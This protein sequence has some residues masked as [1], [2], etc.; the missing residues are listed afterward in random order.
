MAGPMGGATDGHGP[1]DLSRRRLLHGGLAAGTAL[2]AARMGLWS[3]P[4]VTHAQPAPQPA[5]A[6]LPISGSSAPEL[7]AFDRVMT[8]QMAR[9]GLTG[10]ALALA[11]DGRLVFSH[12]Y[13][14]A[15]AETGQ[16]WQPTSL[17]RIAS[18]SKPF[19]AVAI[20]RLVDAG[21]LRLEDKAFPI[22][23]DLPPPANAPRDP[24]LDEITIQQLLQHTGGWD[25]AKSFDPQY[26]P[27]STWAAATLGVAVPPTAE[28]IVRFMLSWP[29]DFD[30]GT[31]YA[32]SNFGYNV[33]GRVIEHVTGLPY[34]DF[35]QQQVLA[36]AGIGDMRLGRTRPEERFPGEVRY[37]NLPDQALVPSVFPGVGYVPNGYGGYYMEA[38]DAH[39]GWIATAEDQLRFATAVDGQRGQ[40]L[41]RPETVAAMLHT[42]LPQQTAASG[43][44]NDPS[45][46]GLCWIVQREG[47]GLSW[48]HAGALE[49]A[50]AAWI[51]RRPD[52]TS[53]SF[54]FNSL[55]TDY[56]TF[57]P[58]L[59]DALKLAAD[60]V[61][62]WPAIDLFAGA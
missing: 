53:I 17:C 44:G 43:A 49:G 37:V 50:C 18:D 14:Y 1:G 32:Y 61:Q 47:D 36:P 12:A 46:S 16:P 24:R 52:G 48:S 4:A 60:A 28:Q 34:G 2:T 19:T 10:G 42:P 54:V 8:E 38:L 39:G 62:R 21:T 20:L 11:K 3:P 57:F 13:G 29:L 30:P 31:R 55:P 6:P 58:A 35:V 27:F 59:G 7:A 45:V 33:L 56:P 5:G 9:W 23:A 41:L 25:S 26:P 22:L 15:D 51:I 40:A